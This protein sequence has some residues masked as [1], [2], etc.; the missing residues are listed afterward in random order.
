MLWMFLDYALPACLLIVYT[1]CHFHYV[2]PVKA[3]TFQS[4][5]SWNKPVL[6]FTQWKHAN[7]MHNKNKKKQ[8]TILDSDVN[9]QILK[10]RKNSNLS[11]VWTQDLGLYP[12]TLSLD[13]S[14]TFTRQMALS[15]E[16]IP[17]DL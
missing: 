13:Y 3:Q 10:Q 8:V 9:I 2:K 17:D 6:Y 1:A 7:C 14:M 5:L 11:R 4:F 15:N 16:H 12:H